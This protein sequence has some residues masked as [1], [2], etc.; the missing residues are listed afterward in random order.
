MEYGAGDLVTAFITIELNEDA[1][2][3]GFV[4]DENDTTKFLE[5]AGESRRAV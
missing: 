3:I 5:G 2:P 1:A 4:V